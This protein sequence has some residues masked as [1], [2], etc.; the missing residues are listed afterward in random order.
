MSQDTKQSAIEAAAEAI[1]AEEQR[2]DLLSLDD[3]EKEPRWMDAIARAAV[4]AYL[5]ALAE[6][7]ASV[8]A[9]ARAIWDVNGYTTGEDADPFKPYA[10]HKM[11][12][13]EGEYAP[14][15]ELHLRYGRRVLAVLLQRAKEQQG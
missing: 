5:S 15:A 6:D 11:I 12:E 3:L 13:D 14:T 4:I 1:N 9:V 7:E 8:E 2:R 10:W